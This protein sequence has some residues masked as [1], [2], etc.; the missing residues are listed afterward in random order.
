[1][2]WA[3]VQDVD[4]LTGVT[5]TDP[6]IAIAQAIIEIHVARTEDVPADTITAR[7]VQW[8]KR[9]V[10]Y[11]TVWVNANPD[12]FTRIEHVTILQDGVEVRDL[13]PDALTLAPL[14]KKAIRRLSWMKT[15]SIHTPSHF[16]QAAVTYPIGG[17]VK[18]YPGEGWSDL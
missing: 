2:G 15:R 1:M 5:V 17:D 8:L 9:A 6:Q 4:D 16:E 12:L 7:D 10:A 13:P 18:D 14:A 3:T 11:Q